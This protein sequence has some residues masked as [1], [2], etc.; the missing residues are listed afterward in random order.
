MR[1]VREQ[2]DC[3]LVD[4]YTARQRVQNFTPKARGTEFAIEIMAWGLMLLLF[5]TAIVMVEV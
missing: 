4:L 2:S 5:V 3:F 1:S